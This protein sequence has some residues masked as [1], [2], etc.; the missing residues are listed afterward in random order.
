MYMHV[1]LFTDAA[2]SFC[3]SQL[4]DLFVIKR[5]LT[6]RAPGIYFLII[7]SLM[8]EQISEIT[9]YQVYC[10]SLTRQRREVIEN[11][12]CRREKSLNCSCWAWQSCIALSESISVDWIIQQ[13]ANCSRFGSQISNCSLCLKRTTKL[14]IVYALCTSFILSWQCDADK[15]NQLIIFS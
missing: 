8:Y 12:G 2:H 6:S 15:I 10:L 7:L 3:V 11:L 4:S 1:K 5:Q 13:T 14:Q 9:V